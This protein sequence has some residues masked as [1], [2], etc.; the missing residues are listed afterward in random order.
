MD[1][2]NA[3][4]DF[5]DVVSD[6]DS[7]DDMHLANRIPEVAQE[8]FQWSHRP[9]LW[10]IR[11]R[12]ELQE[13]VDA[14]D[15]KDLGNIQLPLQMKLCDIKFAVTIADPMQPDFPIVACSPGFSDLTGYMLPEIVGR[16][17]RFLLDGVPRS[18]INEEAR[19]HMWAF[20]DAVKNGANYDGR[21]EVLPSG[22]RPCGGSLAAGEMICVQ[23][24]ARKNGDLFRN[25]FFVKHV[26]I[27]D[28][29][30][31]VGLQTEMPEDCEEEDELQHL[32]AYC[33][34]ARER[35]ASS[36]KLLENL[37]CD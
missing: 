25:M 21:S 5:L 33:D 29:S 35:V 4:K 24:N 12:V 6:E 28:Q 36:M 11:R 1:S 3:F 9:F 18:Q 37:F 14:F 10:N 8:S 26:G 19:F 31:I 32:Q 16:N 34:L 15:L 7:D 22:V 30:Y 2:S 20:C 27:D 13:V 17:C 23:T